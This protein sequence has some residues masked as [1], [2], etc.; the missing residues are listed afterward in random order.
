MRGIIS[1]GIFEILRSSIVLFQ[2][3]FSNNSA[4]FVVISTISSI[5]AG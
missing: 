1:S 2:I 4:S 5:L 3:S